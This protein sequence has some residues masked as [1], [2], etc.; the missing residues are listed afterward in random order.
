MTKNMVKGTIQ[1]AS[2]IG[3]ELKEIVSSPV[4]QE[5]KATGEEAKP[6]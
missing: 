4:E 3:G 6:K 2:E 5:A 1:A